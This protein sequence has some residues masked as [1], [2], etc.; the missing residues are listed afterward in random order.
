MLN[1]K[2]ETVIVFIDFKKVFDSIVR[3]KMLK[4]LLAYGIPL[5]M[6]AWS[7][8]GDVWKHIRAGDNSRR[9]NRP[10]PHIDTGVLQ[11]DPLGPFLFIICL[12]HALWT[13]IWPSDGKTSWK[14]VKVQDT[15]RRF[16]LV[17]RMRMTLHALLENVFKE[18]EDLL[19][20]VE[21]AAQSIGLFLNA[22]KT[23]FM[24][25]NPP[26]DDQMLYLDESEI[27]KVDDCSL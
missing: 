25:L 22:G 12:D 19:H 2:K 16:F 11:G 26:S 8:Q 15:Q 10:V 27:E 4:I 9:K 18:E 20:G 7:N 14:S 1:H 3:T 24:H 23:K 17:S 5:Q 13:A 21:D 6:H